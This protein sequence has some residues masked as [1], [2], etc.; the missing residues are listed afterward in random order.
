MKVS[1]L[2][3]VTL[4]YIASAI[5]VLSQSIVQQN[6]NLM[7]QAIKDRDTDEIRKLAATPYVFMNET[8]MPPAYIEQ[9]V[10]SGDIPTLQTV[11]DVGARIVQSGEVTFGKI[12]INCFMQ[13]TQAGRKDLLQALI[14]EFKREKQT[15]KANDKPYTL[16]QMFATQRDGLDSLMTAF[17]AKRDDLA[18]IMLQNAA[19]P[20][21]RSSYGVTALWYAA[22][23]LNLCEKCFTDAIQYHA[24]PNAL[25]STGKTRLFDWTYYGNATDL[26][27]VAFL[28]K[29]VDVNIRDIDGLSAYD[30]TQAKGRGDGT[31]QP[32]PPAHPGVQEILIKAGAQTRTLPA[33]FR[34]R[35]GT[36]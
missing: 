18:L 25:D 11:F 13:A 23:Q 8:N 27:G 17:R 20:N 32:A 34:C 5:P 35:Y 6:H 16:K 7:I 1:R 15:P 10:Q 33:V 9:A 12:T 31:C 22:Q 21:A 2:A 3:V 24:D 36:H 19:D 29:Y 26:A 4:V 30:Y 14:S 28:V